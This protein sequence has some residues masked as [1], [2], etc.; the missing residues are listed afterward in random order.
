M[1][2]PDFQDITLPLLQ[3][4]KDG[5]PHEISELKPKIAAHFHLTEEEQ[6][7]LLPSG[8][9]GGTRFGNRFGW[10]R[11]HLKMAG[12]INYERSGVYRITDRGKQVLIQAPTKLDVHFLDQF[13]EHVEFRRGKESPAAKPESPLSD[14]TP[15]ERLEQEYATIRGALSQDLL[16]RIGAASPAFF[17]RLVVQLLM[18]MGYGGSDPAA[19]KTIG[20]TG[21]D[22]IDGTINEDK[23]G[24]DIIYIQAKRWKGV[25]GRPVVQAFAGSLEGNRAQ[26]GVLITTS[27]F[28]ADAREFVKRI[29]KKIVLIDGEMLSDLMIDYGVGVIEENSYA[30][31]RIDSDYFSE[32]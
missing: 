6:S 24:L 23:L 27:Q 30:V 28:S 17:E 5:Q 1:P 19:G 25:V 9:K 14:L 16:E 31:K 20:R 12:L 15:Q 2:I 29:G 11:T 7:E 21:D 26:K 4:L 22:G 32:E 3:L 10:A 18:A 8:P 13:P